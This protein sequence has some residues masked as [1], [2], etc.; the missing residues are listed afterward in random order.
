MEA[1]AQEE[2]IVNPETGGKL[3]K[4]LSQRKKQRKFNNQ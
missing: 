4:R 1:P 2:E 3:L